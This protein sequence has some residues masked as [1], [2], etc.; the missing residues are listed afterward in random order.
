M[1][2]NQQPDNEQQILAQLKE[3]FSKDGQDL[4]SYLQGLYHTQYLTYWDYIHLDTLLSLQNP[5][6]AFPDEQIFVVYHQIAELYF[7]LILFEI[8][9]IGLE[10]N[11]QSFITRLDRVNKYWEQIMSSFDDVI[12]SISKQEFGQFRTALMP[13]SGFQS[14]QFREIEM[15]STKMNFLVDKENRENLVT[16]TDV[17]GDL[18]E[19]IYWKK[20]SIDSRTG[21]KTLTLIQFEEKY[22]DYLKIQALKFKENNLLALIDKISFSE[23]EWSVAKKGLRHL[24]EVV[25]I[26]FALIH[27]KAAVKHLSQKPK[28]KHST[29]G[30]N[31]Q[32]YLPPRFQ[33]VI[34]FPHLWTDEELN[35]W[36]KSFIEGVIAS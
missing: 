24:D 31:W 15:A 16:N 23:E 7:K 11:A 32:G 1:H 4:N 10:L 29:G 12:G 14:A 19:N 3:R 17:A 28:D 27:Y 34:F 13:A 8:K 35:N 33:K 6:T 30:T 25:N 9:H 20:G 36:G 18:Y 2:T 21:N 26:R 5:K 22:D